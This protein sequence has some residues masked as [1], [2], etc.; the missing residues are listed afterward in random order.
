[1][2]Y[3]PALPAATV[4]FWKR[5]R[6][7]VWATRG[8]I[9]TLA[10]L[11]W[12][13]VCGVVVAD[14]LHSTEALMDLLPDPPIGVPEMYP[15]TPLGGE[16]VL[17]EPI[18]WGA[19]VGPASMGR[20]L[21]MSPFQPH[22]GFYFGREL[23]YWWTRGQQVPALATTSPS[24]T[25]LTDAGELGLPTTT[26]LLGD[27]RL[28][29][30][31]SV[32]G[33]FAFGWRF[34]PSGCRAAEFEYFTL[35]SGVEQYVYGT[36]ADVAILSRPFF[37]TFLDEQDAELVGFPDVVDGQL[38]LRTTTDLHGFALLWKRNLLCRRCDPCCKLEG[39]WWKSRNLA[40]MAATA[41]TQSLP[42]LLSALRLRV[43]SQSCRSVPWLSQPGL[44]RD[45]DHS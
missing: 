31:S 44:R 8:C 4:V 6:L 32:G 29:A 37:N 26:T 38:S 16:W 18:H 27:G 40:K 33:R 10:S 21:P 12:I 17:S 19:D 28:A 1:M 9:A 42:S 30:E 13:F 11:A 15:S 7:S 41:E 22:T 36:P 20:R 34:G 43:L 45:A 2:R 39:P 24:G 3:P 5:P 35:E 23:L 14:D 25:P